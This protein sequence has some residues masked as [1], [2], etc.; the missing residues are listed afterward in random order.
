MRL[1]NDDAFARL[2]G[3]EVKNRVSN[4]QREFLNLPENND[5]WQA[6]LGALLE[7]LDDQLGDL[8]EREDRERERYEALGPDGAALLAAMITDVEGRRKKIARFRFHVERRLESVQRQEAGNS[9]LIEER[10]RLVEFLRKAIEQHQSMI[11]ETDLDPTPIDH[12]LWAAL[13]GEWTFD[14]INIDDI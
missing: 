7:N 4:S 9:E 11:A 12:A 3:D 13:N 8:Q 1:M 2:V 5:R 6:A 10:A 14:K